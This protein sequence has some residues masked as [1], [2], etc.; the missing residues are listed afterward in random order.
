MRTCFTGAPANFSI[1]SRPNPPLR[2]R[3]SPVQVS[4]SPRLSFLRCFRRRYALSHL[5]RGARSRSQ[6]SK[7]DRRHETNPP[8]PQTALSS[9]VFHNAVEETMEA[10]NERNFNHPEGERKTLSM[11][12]RVAGVTFRA[13]RF[14][15]IHETNPTPFSLCFSRLALFHLPPPTRC[16]PWVKRRLYSP[17]P[18]PQAI[19]TKL[20][21]TPK[22]TFLVRTADHAPLATASTPSLW[23]TL[24]SSL[25]R[26]QFWVRFSHG[27]SGEFAVLV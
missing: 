1:T 14:P 5:W 23:K 20:F 10:V 15:G 6:M 17:C 21:Q 4:M 27:L 16:S 26:F 19:N 7:A 25:C 18:C 9:R 3:T 8:T 22:R 24:I 2:L 11:I 12:D 13:C